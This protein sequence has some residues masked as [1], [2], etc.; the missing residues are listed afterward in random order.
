MIGRLIR[1]SLGALVISSIGSVIAAL[2]IKQRTP[3]VGNAESDEIAL[4]TIF[5]ELA[6]TSTAK[7]FRGGSLTCW[8][9]GGDLDLRDAALDPAGARLTV[10]LVFG[11]GRVLVPDDWA[12]DL[13]ATSVF[14][15]MSDTRE[16]S[17]RDAAAP[18]LVIDGTVVFGGLAIVSSKAEAEIDLAAAVDEATAS[19]KDTADDAADAVTEL[20]PAL[21][22]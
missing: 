12:I 13:E 18:R 14:G 10:K 4:V 8:Y 9:G 7:A 20:V 11:G 1:W 15:G 19:V 5:E 21:D 2:V 3:S 6:F 17:I 16:T 22:V